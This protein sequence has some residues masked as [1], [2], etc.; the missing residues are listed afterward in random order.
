MQDIPLQTFRNAIRTQDLTLTAELA[1]DGESDGP[2]V[3]A[4][5]RTLIEAVDAVQVTDNP[6]LKLHLSPLVAAAI[7]LNE[8]IDP[9]VHIAC[10]DRNSIALRSDLLGAA[11]LGVTSLLLMRGKDIPKDARPRIKPVYDWGTRK[12]ITCASG[13]EKANFMIGSIATVF[14]PETDWTPGGLLAKAD[15]GVKFVQSPL[16][17]DIDLL[18]HY[19]SRLVSKKLMHR[20][21]VI[22]A[23]APIPSAD[24]AEWLV[25]NLRGVI[26]PEKIIDRLRGATDPEKEGISICAELLRESAGIP[27]ISGANLV[28]LGD[29]EAVTEAIRLSGVRR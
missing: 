16:C 26:I 7:L 25:E 6:G 21:S 24:M 8:G 20:V 5:A 27:G 3:I 28:C 17:F 1:L 2:S 13:I 19:M 10:R 23:L 14:E 11:A 22:V 29:P 15:A 12:L 4:Q 9:V 18:K